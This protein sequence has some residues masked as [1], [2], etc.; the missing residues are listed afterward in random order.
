MV[1][2]GFLG[3][4]DV[5]A[6]VSVL[7]N[8][9]PGPS[10][11]MACGLHHACPLS[12][13]LFNLV[14]AT[15]PILI[16]QCQ[17]KVWFQGISISSLQDPIFVLQFADDTILFLCRSTNVATRVQHCLTIFFMIS[18]LSIN[19]LRALSWDWWR[20]GFRI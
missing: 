15:L 14:A 10:L 8:G 17:S 19:Y 11:H 4:V 7:V 20:F 13:L 9:S 12:P 3:L 1:R 6:F 18:G 5:S 16:N 2:S